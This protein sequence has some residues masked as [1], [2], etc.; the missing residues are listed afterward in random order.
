MVDAARLVKTLTPMSSEEAKRFG[1]KEEDRKQFI[2]VDNGKVNITRGGGAP[3]W[4]E[5][6]GVAL[7]NGNDLY[8]KGDEVQTVRPWKPP[9]I[10]ADLTDATL[11]KILDKIAEGFP[12]GERY[13][14]HNRAGKRGAWRAV[15][16]LAPEKTLEQAKEIIKTWLKNEVLVAEDYHSKER[17]EETAPEQSRNE[18]PMGF[19]STGLQRDSESVPLKKL[20]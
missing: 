17:G 10:W 7:G 8:P 13:S 19:F 12:D 20:P 18:V 3:Q 16:E 1:I 11:N 15:I 2:R 5:L 6:V 4:F 14:D 9:D